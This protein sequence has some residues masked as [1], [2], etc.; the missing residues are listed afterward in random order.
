MGEDTK[1]V[2]APSQPLS[3]TAITEMTQ[4]EQWNKKNPPTEATIVKDLRTTEL[5]AREYRGDKGAV[6][7][8]VRRDSAPAAPVRAAAEP[9]S[10]KHRHT[11]EAVLYIVKGKGHTVMH[12]DGEPEER[13]DWEEGRS[14][15]DPPLGMAPASSTTR[16]MTR[17]ATLPSRT[18]SPS[19]SSACTRSSAIRTLPTTSDRRP[20]T[21]REDSMTEAW[22]TVG[23]IERADFYADWLAASDRNAMLVERSP[24]VARGRDLVWIETPQDFRVAMLIGEQV[25][26]PT[27]GTNL[28]RATIPA[29]HHT[30]RHR[31]GEEAIHVLGGEGFVLVGGR[32]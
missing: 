3:G 9:R 11:T 10:V 14:D 4:R 2:A 1:V 19:S 29:G 21:T 30:G 8:P 5:I 18:R 6:L 17:P 7:S 16:P 13:V 15:R 24:I 31:H 20:E 28:C 27:N 25:G 26:F 32:R 22:R 23:R 12:Y